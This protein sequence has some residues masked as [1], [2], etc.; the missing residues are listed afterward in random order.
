MDGISVYVCMYVCM[1]VCEGKEL[2]SLLGAMAAASASASP[3]ASPASTV[4]SQPCSISRR[5]VL[6]SSGPSLLLL[7]PLPG[8]SSTKSS[9]STASSDRITGNVDRVVRSDGDPLRLLLASADDV[10]LSRIEPLLSQA[11][12]AWA[13]AFDPNDSGTKDYNLDI[14]NRLF[15]KIVALDP[16][17]TEWLEA[18]GQVFSSFI[19]NGL[20]FIQL[21]EIG[22]KSLYIVL[23]SVNAHMSSKEKH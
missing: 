17:H 8:L 19:A 1:Y 18:R 22:D 21:K 10:D 11:A 6:L 16:L 9:S 3:V 14:A 12:E 7:L 20:P 2:S 5:S 15:D 23:L 4:R 13:R